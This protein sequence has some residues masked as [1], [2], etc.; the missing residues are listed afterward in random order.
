MTDSRKTEVC[1]HIARERGAVV[2]EAVD[3]LGDFAEASPDD[4]I[5]H[6]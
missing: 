5:V 4:Q 2:I 1:L 6:H 3:S